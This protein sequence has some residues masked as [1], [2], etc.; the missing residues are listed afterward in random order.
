MTATREH[1]N[2]ALIEA[3]IA[4]APQELEEVGEL[5][6]DLAAHLPEGFPVIHVEI[7]RA[8][9]AGGKLEDKVS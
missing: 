1:R 5:Y 6:R 8:Q 7:D 3:H 4:A 9:A 2:P